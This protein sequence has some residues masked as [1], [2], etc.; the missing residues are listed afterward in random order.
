MVNPWIIHVKKWSAEHNLSYSCSISDPECKKSY[1]S[2]KSAPSPTE[3]AAPKTPAK[4]PKAPK[5]KVSTLT[6]AEIFKKILELGKKVDDAKTAAEGQKYYNE[7]KKLM[8]L[9]KTVK[10]ILKE[11]FFYILNDTHIL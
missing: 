4:A 5:A 7:K 6:K 8:E 2:S 1:H 10:Q 11:Y 9:L 3:V